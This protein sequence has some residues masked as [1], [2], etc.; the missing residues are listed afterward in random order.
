VP[1]CLIRSAPIVLI[2]ANSSWEKTTQGANQVLGCL[3]VDGDPDP[4][5]L[6]AGLLEIAASRSPLTLDIAATALA[7]IDEL[8]ARHEPRG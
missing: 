5:A 8:V 4:G 6:A 1:A 7:E 3:I 2:M